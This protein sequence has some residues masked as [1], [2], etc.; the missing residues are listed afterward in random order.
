MVRARAA[1][2]SETPRASKK[3]TLGIAC[4]IGNTPLVP[5]ENLNGNPKVRILGKLEGANLS[6]SIKDR[7]AHYMLTKAEESGDLTKDKIII[8]ATSGNMGIALAA[9]GAAKGYRLK[10]F[11]PE[12]DVSTPAGINREI[13]R[14]VMMCPEQYLWGYNR[15]KGK[16]E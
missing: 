15:Y 1:A 3:R 13:E 11:M 12:G 5:L 2:K 6:G 16:P 14:L 9:I 8:E 4:A 7:P 10:L